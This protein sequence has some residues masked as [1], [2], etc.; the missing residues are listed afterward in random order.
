M[1]KKLVILLVFAFAI[2]L[3]PVVALAEEQSNTSE[4]EQVAAPNVEKNGSQS[5]SL[6]IEEALKLAEANNSTLKQAK[7]SRDQSKIKTSQAHA[8]AR[9]V[10]EEEATTLSLGLTKYYSEKAAKIALDLAEKTYAVAHEQVNLLVKKDYL[11][12]LKKKELV[13]VKQLAVERAQ[14]QLDTANINFQVGTV[15]KTDVLTAEVGLAQ[16]K[17]ELTSANNNL[18]LAEI[19]LCTA[20]GLDTGT[21]LNLTSTIAYEAF[22][23]AD[24]QKVIEESMAGHLEI[25]SKLA[26]KDL[27]V[28]NYNITVDYS[29]AGTYGALLAKNSVDVAAL[30]LEDAKDKVIANITSAYLNVLAAEET[31]NTYT[32]SL[33]S[34]E[35]SARLNSLRYEVGM[36]TSYDVL[37][38]SVQLSN[39]AA[40]KVEAIYN[41]YLAKLAFETSKLALTN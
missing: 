31:V 2:I 10:D 41:H 7:L 40:S 13:K 39:V 28:E 17:A 33:A 1:F 26:A 35:E 30:N 12:V 37:N 18:K 14:K 24:L 23:P 21:K 19:T 4:N 9:K 15:A 20:L 34:A 5:V 27:A 11:D 25:A 16:A 29:A 32:A 22:V 36:A 8:G 6:S 3:A 38:A